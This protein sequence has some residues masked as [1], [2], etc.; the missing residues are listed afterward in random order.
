MLHHHAIDIDEPT[1]IP[2]GDDE[3]VEQENREL[4]RIFAQTAELYPALNVQ[5]PRLVATV[6]W[7]LLAM[8]RGEFS[9]ASGL[10]GR[11]VYNLEAK[12][13]PI[14]H[15]RREN[16]ATLVASWS[17]HHI[18]QDVCDQ[19]LDIFQEHYGG[20]HGLYRRLQFECGS[21]RFEQKT[22]LSSGSLSRR[23]KSHTVPSYH[24]VH[25]IIQTLFA[26]STVKTLRDRRT[27]QAQHVW[28]E[29]K[30]SQL[31]ERELEH[32][33]TQFLIALEIFCAEK[34]TSVLSGPTLTNRLPKT[35]QLTSYAARSLINGQLIPWEKVE[36]LAKKVLQKEEYA[37]VKEAWLEAWDTE[38]QRTTFE[39]L[40]RKTMKEYGVHMRDISYAL[41]ILDSQDRGTARKKDV[42]RKLP[43]RESANLSHVLSGGSFYDQATARAMV[44]AL[45]EDE[46]EQDAL[47]EAFRDERRRFY[48][49]SGSDLQGER[50]EM[51]IDR[52]WNGVTPECLAETVL[53]AQPQSSEDMPTLAKRIRRIEWGTA[54]AD[55]VKKGE[56]SMLR[57]KTWQAGE[58]PVQRI[59]A[60]QRRADAVP[61]HLLDVHFSS[62]ADAIGMLRK[63]T[64][65]YDKISEIIR[66]HT[67]DPQLFVG[68]TNLPRIEKTG[69]VPPWPV[70]QSLCDACGLTKIEGMRRNWHELF[71]EQLWTRDRLPL[72]RPL[73]RLLTTL[74]Y[75]TEPSL[76]RFSQERGVPY[77]QVRHTIAVLENGGWPDWSP[78]VINILSAADIKRSSVEWRLAQYLY[79]NDDDVS[80]AVSMLSRQLKREGKDI[81][82]VH[83]PGIT[84]SELSRYIST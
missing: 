73:P 83:L 4:E 48:R 6:R 47:H 52:E 51:T 58:D 55:E 75:R 11:T 7:S 28:R 22:G 40:F 2:V 57:E 27:L 43:F 29:E 34:Y 74:V 41:N 12:V 25:T 36:H 38:Q 69:F 24:E 80:G 32:P 16:I 14:E 79:E 53:R 19:L 8:S 10:N 18:S 33:L 21:K 35:L 39:S 82:P 45:T 61:R 77:G 44:A 71:P 30:Q 20:I 26:G 62:I 3:G 13:R 64:G 81:H 67:S 31:T 1:L 68:T 78:N 23:T 72:A 37:T 84:L 63:G 70:L 50:L 15:V 49:R 65:S 59:P 60:R 46:N 17:K 56:V 42:D 9:D 54:R 76:N 66:A 5:L